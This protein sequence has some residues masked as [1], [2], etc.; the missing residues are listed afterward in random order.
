MVYLIA[1]R[2]DLVPAVY[3]VEIVCLFAWRLVVFCK[4][5]WHHF[6]LDIC[7]WSN[8][9]LVL[10]ILMFPGDPRIFSV[11]FALNN[12]VVVGG[13]LFFRPSLV[14]HDAQYFTSWYMHIVPALVTY[15]LRT[16]DA[17]SPLRGHG[18]FRTCFA[19][20]AGGCGVA[21]T[22]ETFL[23]HVA[24]PCAFF[25]AQ[26]VVYLLWVWVVPHPRLRRRPTY[27]NS[28]LFLLAKWESRRGGGGSCL[29]RVVS[30]G[31]PA[32]PRWRLLTTYMLCN[33][34]LMW[35]LCLCSAALFQY[36]RAH[37]A[38]LLG[39]LAL[40]TYF[41]GT[42]YRH[43]IRNANRRP[44]ARELDP[45]THAGLYRLTLHRHHRP[46][47][48][49]GGADVGGKRLFNSAPNWT[50]V[51]QN[52]IKK[53]KQEIHK[54]LQGLDSATKTLGSGKGGFGGDGDSHKRRV[55]AKFR[56][57]EDATLDDENRVE[58]LHLASAGE[59]TVLDD[60]EK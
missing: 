60:V 13:G 42:F 4:K 56:H 51:G 48:A 6:L 55:T 27:T 44:A 46:K 9:L 45:Q 12:G 22:R 59:E 53:D 23:W 37:A 32:A 58:G 15:C 30:C 3:V 43:V 25:T 7:Y 28:F 52:D 19:P 10:Y 17:W 49:G 47:N 29:Y 57:G 2:P 14:F 33:T 41:G 34:L 11:A 21:A 1:A 24:A 35:T 16:A 36:K 20:D 54:F 40:M 50:E 18:H 39:V 31:K 38:Y 5:S 26:N 8:T